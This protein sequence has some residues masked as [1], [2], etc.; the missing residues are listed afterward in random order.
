MDLQSSDRDGEALSFHSEL[1]EV[2]P[3]GVREG[4]MVLL[5]LPRFASC[6]IS[7][8]AEKEREKEGAKNWGK[9]LRPNKQPGCLDPVDGFVISS[10]RHLI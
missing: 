6:Y 7:A 10:L 2:E 1:W 5:Q 8:P 3:W 9:T 4:C